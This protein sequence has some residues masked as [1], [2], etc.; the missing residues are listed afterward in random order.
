M[1][2]G[3]RILEREEDVMELVT[4]CMG[5]AHIS[6]EDDAAFYRA[7]FGEGDWVLETGQKLA[8][9]IVSNNQIDIKDGDILMQGRHGR[10][11]KNKVDSCTITNGAQGKVRHDLIVLRYQK[12]GE[13]KEKLTTVVIKGTPGDKGT[14]PAYQKGD[15]ETGASVNEMPLYRVVITGLNI[16]A[17]Q[18]LFRYHPG[19]RRRIRSGD[20][21]PTDGLEGDI[22]LLRES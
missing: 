5:E 1:V 20:S 14:D 9:E 12:D 13:G 8:Y 10:L 15:L 6:A 21:L 17:V 4:G 18:P 2:D 19:A 3:D 22:F 7:I 11:E 16:T